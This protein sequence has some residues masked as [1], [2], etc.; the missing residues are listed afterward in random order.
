M[1]QMLVVPVYL[2]QSRHNPC[3]QYI[4]LPT[5]IV[6]SHKMHSPGLR[7][8]TPRPA[9][10]GLGWGWFRSWRA[11]CRPAFLCGDGTVCNHLR[12]L[13]KTVRKPAAPTVDGCEIHFAPPKKPKVRFPANTNKL[14]VQSWCLRWCKRI[15]SIHST[16]GSSFSRN[17]TPPQKKK[18]WLG[19]SSS[20]VGPSQRRRLP[21]GFPL[22][23]FQKGYPTPKKKTPDPLGWGPLKNRN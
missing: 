23:P 21:V 10:G 14:W 22:R 7:Q 19:S 8:R 16:S 18:G 2:L 11:K 13:E 15:S 20:K 6:V 5:W 12:R 17:R 4:I 1:A 9:G 3:R